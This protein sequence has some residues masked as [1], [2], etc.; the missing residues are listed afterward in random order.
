MISESGQDT[1]TLVPTRMPNKND[2]GENLFLFTCPR[3]ILFCM[4]LKIS[5]TSKAI[6]LYILSN[7][8]IGPVKF[9]VYLILLAFIYVVIKK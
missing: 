6:G 5:R 3:S 9:L 1:N 8:H 7:H 4:K 2:M